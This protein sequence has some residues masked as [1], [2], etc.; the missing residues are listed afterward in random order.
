[1]ETEQ[2]NLISRKLDIIVHILTSENIKD[3]KSQSEKILAL[4]SYGY[5]PT[6]IA[7]F[8]NTTPNT[9]SVR[10]SKAKKRSSMIEQETKK[11]E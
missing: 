2:F 5:T 1:M 6:E 8:L 11:D 9:V 3:L 4:S 7:S 10:L